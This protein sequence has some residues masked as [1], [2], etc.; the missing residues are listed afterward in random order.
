MA[1][2]GWGEHSYTEDYKEANGRE[3]SNKKDKKYRR[4]E[5]QSPPLHTHINVETVIRPE[6]KNDKGANYKATEM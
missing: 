5:N 2:V 6:G 3:G 4:R 1:V